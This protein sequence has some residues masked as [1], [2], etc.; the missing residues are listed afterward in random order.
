MLRI[1]F[2]TL[3]YASNIFAA[4]YKADNKLK[5]VNAPIGSPILDINRSR[6]VLSSMIFRPNS[7]V[8]IACLCRVPLLVPACKTT[9]IDQLERFINKATRRVVSP[10][11]CMK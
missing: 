8:I 10:M 2:P 5:E 1:V 9:D 11:S 4:A 3:G 6:A 7:G